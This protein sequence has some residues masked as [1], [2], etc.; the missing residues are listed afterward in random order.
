M[1][2]GVAEFARLGYRGASTARIAALAGVP[3]PHVYANFQAKSQLFLAC[4]ENVVAAIAPGREA[5]RPASS[6]RDAVGDL[7][8]R[9]VLQLFAA[10]GEQEVAA[11]VR[12]LLLR[13]RAALGQRALERLVATAAS[14]LL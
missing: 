6:P 9:F 13:L 12:P 7:H 10:L 1:E 5:D 11:E 8:A 2:A 14:G 4:A 3:Q